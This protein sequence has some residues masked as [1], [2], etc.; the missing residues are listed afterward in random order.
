MIS[1]ALGCTP[2]KRSKTLVEQHSLDSKLPKTKQRKVE[3]SVEQDV[4]QA[5][6]DNLKMLSPFELDGLVVDG[7]T[8][9][10]RLTQDK[11]E[12]RDPALRKSM[13]KTYYRHL[14]QMYTAEGNAGTS[15]SV[16]SS[17]KELPIDPRLLKAV[18]ACQSGR[19][20][21]ALMVGYLGHCEKPNA[22]DRRGCLNL[23][24]PFHFS[25]WY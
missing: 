11:E 23:F 5:I 17:G 21:R 6:R 7:K 1:E 14:R 4:E 25:V 18:V 2:L 8:C 24:S 13:G 9:R 22:K 19:P 10:Q 20:N 15:I 12:W 16:P 3:R